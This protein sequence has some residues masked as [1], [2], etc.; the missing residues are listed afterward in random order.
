[1]KSLYSIVLFFSI[2]Y[3]TNA[4]TLPD[5]IKRKELKEVKVTAQSAAE[6]AGS[7]S[8][9]AEVINTAAVKEQPSTLIELMNRSAGV[10]IKQSGGLG[11]S[12]NL[13]LNGF[14]NRAVK[15]FKDG[16]PLD[17]LGAG[18]IYTGQGRSI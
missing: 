9:K 13:I 8:I 18:L 15:Y 2:Y 7:Q 14:Q 3:T 5:T 17:Y 1:M 10:R 11:A 6:K 12:S 16:I 4:Q